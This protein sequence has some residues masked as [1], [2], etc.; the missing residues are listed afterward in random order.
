MILRSLAIASVLLMGAVT[1]GLV[2][3]NHE[4][5]LPLMGVLE[6]WLTPTDSA[7]PTAAMRAPAKPGLPA[8][9][10]RVNGELHEL[11]ASVSS[12]LGGSRITL[13]MKDAAASDVAGELA[14]QARREVKM[15]IADAAQ[16]T[17]LE[18]EDAPFWHA[19]MALCEAGDWGFTVYSQPGH[20]IEVESDPSGGKITSWA[21]AGPLL[22]VWHQ[23][24]ANRVSLMIEPS[25]S[26]FLV[27]PKI[28]PEFSLVLDDGETQPWMAAAEMQDAM[29]GRAWELGNALP[30]ELQ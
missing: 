2:Q 21:V 4:E 20:P 19:L 22:L 10:Y 1:L 5:L 18:L 14:R 6:P 17:T 27:K 12:W 26:A 3:L 11:P 9:Q 24:D 30:A 7:T 28:D 25:S 8:N 16:L 23:G 15:G 13:S 29:G